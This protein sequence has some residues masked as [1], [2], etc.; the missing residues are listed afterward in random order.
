MSDF[1]TN[2]FSLKGKIVFVTGGSSGLGKHFCET[3]AMA[4]AEV[5]TIARHIDCLENLQKK[6][7][8][9]GG[10][11]HIYACDLLSKDM[12]ATVL[13]EI[14]LRHKI[15]VLVN[16]AGIFHH[17]PIEDNSDDFF[18]DVMFLNVTAL[19]AVIQYV[20]KNMKKHGT[21][22]SIINIASIYGGGVT[23]PNASAY[24]ASKA[25]VMQMTK[26]LVGE[27]STHGIR[28]NSISPGSVR[29]EMTQNAM[30]TCEK[31]LVRSIPTGNIGEVEEFDGILL[32][33]S[34]NRASSYINGRDIVVDGGSS[35]GG[36]IFDF[37]G[38]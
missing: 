28:I 25:A 11:C 31:S 18:E 37:S 15:D 19:W 22:G 6:I 1:L 13:K 27:L 8:K 20:V 17:T 38:E 32:M 24:W 2:L 23:S 5:V 36:N 12:R 7:E 35:W 14:M 4:G 21:K 33:L 10:V 29:T 34:S 16:A 9:K 3:V 30:T 26:Q